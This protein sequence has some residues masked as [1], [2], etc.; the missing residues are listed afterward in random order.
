[1]VEDNYISYLVS[2]YDSMYWLICLNIEGILDALFMLKMTEYKIQYGKN[3]YLKK[4]KT[5][6]TEK[7]INKQKN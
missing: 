4:F 6:K 5:I 1:M 2:D 7:Q 3:L